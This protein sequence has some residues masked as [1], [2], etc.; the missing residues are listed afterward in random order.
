MLVVKN[1]GHVFEIEGYDVAAT[2]RH[3]KEMPVNGGILFVRSDRLQRAQSF[4]Q[5]VEV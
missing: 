2:W 3:Q 5:Y 4:F 1:M